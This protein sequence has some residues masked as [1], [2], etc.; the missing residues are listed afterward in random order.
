MNAAKALSEKLRTHNVFGNFTVVNVA[1]NGD[2]DEENADAL[3]LVNKAIGPDPDETYTIT[4][5][6]GRL[7][8][9]V[10]VK[11]WT[12]VFMMSGTFSTSAA[13]YMQTIFR[14]QTP[15]TCHG[16][17][18]TNCYAFDFAPDRTLRVLAKVAKVSAKAEIGRASCRE[19]V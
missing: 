16:K 6:C 10:S 9:G 18:K 15:F 8:T 12:A 2:E 1:G 4:L 17:M 14:V 5:T 3:Q 13:S 11:P 19:R 7:T